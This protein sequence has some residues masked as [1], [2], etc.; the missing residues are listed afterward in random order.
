MNSFYPFINIQSNYWAWSIAIFSGIKWTD[1][2]CQL[3]KWKWTLKS[4]WIHFMVLGQYSLSEIQPI[5]NCNHHSLNLSL[6]LFVICIRKYSE[7][8]VALKHFNILSWLPFV[9]LQATHLIAFSNHLLEILN[10]VVT[11]HQI[12]NTTLKI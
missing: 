6:A 12:L 3:F 5:L 8:W 7:V 10:R 11:Y 4:V 1:F 2:E 9:Q